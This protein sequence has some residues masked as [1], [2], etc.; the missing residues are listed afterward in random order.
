MKLLYI[1]VGSILFYINM[2]NVKAMDNSVIQLNSNV[3]E[4]VELVEPAKVTIN[5]SSP[6]GCITHEISTSS[7]YYIEVYSVCG[8]SNTFEYNLN[9]GTYYIDTKGNLDAPNYAMNIDIKPYKYNEFEPNS[10]LETAQ[11]ITNNTQIN[12]FLGVDDYTDFYILNLEGPGKLEVKLESNIEN[13]H[14]AMLKPDS[15]GLMNVIISTSNSE[16]VY[17]FYIDKGTYLIQMSLF[18]GGKFITGDYQFELMFNPILT[19]EIESNDNKETAQLI[20]VNEKING[21][22]S[23]IDDDVFKLTINE[24]MDLELNLGVEFNAYIRLY[25]EQDVDNELICTP[26]RYDFMEYCSIFIKNITGSEGNP[27]LYSETISLE[28]GTYYLRVGYFGDFSYGRYF[29]D[30]SKKIFNDISTHWAKDHILN[31]VNKGYVKGYNDG[32]FR[33][34]DSITRAEFV[35]IVNSVFGLSEKAEIAFTDIDRE[36]QK[37]QV[38]IGVKAGYLSTTNLTFR[39]NDPITRQEACKI[40]GTL[41]NL[42][43][44][45]NMEFEDSNDIASWAKIYV[46]GLV[47][48]GII[49]K[50]EKFRPQDGIRRGEAV[51]ILNLVMELI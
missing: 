51:K 34:D 38:A 14:F 37:E 3:R 30:F 12:G 16:D 40:V 15:T 18:S 6:N 26:Y 39:P 41:A 47:D 19:N 24:H 17:D 45:E 22:L 44:H 25:N 5:I 28:P 32:T 7:G 23:V 13:G 1:L 21:L 46:S 35:K 29:V 20:N 43:G 2:F 10:T 27:T 48:A 11:R 36:W 4:V 31:F 9:E 50:K 42:T 33:P 49:T 8:Q